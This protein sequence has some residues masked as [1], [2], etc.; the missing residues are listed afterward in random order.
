MPVSLPTA[1]DVRAQLEGYNINA[2]LVSDT[3]INNEM[4]DMIVPYIE[5]V[6]RTSL[7]SLVQVTEWYSGNGSSILVMNRRNIVQLITIA[8]VRGSDFLS[9][10]NLDAI[11]LVASEGILKARTRVSEGYYFSIFPKGEDNLRIT[12]TYG[13][14][15]DAQLALAVKYLACITVLDNLEGRTGGGSISTEGWT[16]DFG[17]QGKYSNYRRKLAARA[18]WIL[19]QYNTSVVGA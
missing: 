4:S 10:I 3:F 1:A 7:Q 14:A 5:K 6:C 9:Y 8:L 15:L 13:N 17:S 18:L 16:R 12:Y 2:S 19:N 11:D